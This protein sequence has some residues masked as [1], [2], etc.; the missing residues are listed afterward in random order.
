MN[1]VT[2]RLCTLH[3]CYRC[4]IPTL[5][6]VPL[7]HCLNIY[8]IRRYIKQCP[9]VRLS[10]NNI[11]HLLLVRQRHSFYSWT[12]PNL[13]EVA[14]A[15]AGWQEALQPCSRRRCTPPPASA[16][17]APPTTPCCQSIAAGRDW[18]PTARPRHP[19]FAAPS[20]RERSRRAAL[21]AA[22]PVGARL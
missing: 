1:I 19:S 5:R 15:A 8:R 20:L 13:A 7:L 16:I 3:G 11:L 12:A 4:T 9:N 21:R 6:P 10:C 22:A 2:Y 17:V 14:P 18:P